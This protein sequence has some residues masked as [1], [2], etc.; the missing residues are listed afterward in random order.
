MKSMKRVFVTAFAVML[1]CLFVLSCLAGAFHSCHNPSGCLFC[2]T[3][4]EMRRYL[5]VSAV[6]SF[7]VC[8]A[9]AVITVTAKKR[10]APHE[11]LAQLCV[12]LSE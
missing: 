1:F 2:K 11:S 12:K 3:F 4:S 10:T 7:A 9:T 8:A 5:A 6:L